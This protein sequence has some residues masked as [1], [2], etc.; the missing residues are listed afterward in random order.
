[1]IPT[2][3]ALPGQQAQLNLGLGDVQRGTQQEQINAQMQK[4]QEAKQYPFQM[5]EVLGRTIGNA[6]GGGAGTTTQTGP[7]FFPANRTADMLGGSAAV[8]GL[9]SLLRGG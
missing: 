8:A 1:M 7:G 2:A 6:L 5:A 3:T 4:F 9:L